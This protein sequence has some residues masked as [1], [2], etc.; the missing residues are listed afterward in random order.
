[1]S[2][3]YVGTESGR[4]YY[5][6]SL[7]HRRLMEEMKENKTLMTY[8]ALVEKEPAFAKKDDDDYH[9]H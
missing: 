2:N 9:Y 7:L 1:M 6:H 5:I 3:I 8:C 4:I